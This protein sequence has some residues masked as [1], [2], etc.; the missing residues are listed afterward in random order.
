MPD[1]SPTPPEADTVT[2]EPSADTSPPAAA[3][4]ATPA[5]QPAAEKPLQAPVHGPDT[6]P[7]PTSAPAASQSP[8]PAGEEAPLP[9]PPEPVGFARRAAAAV[10]FALYGAV[11]AAAWFVLHFWGLELAPF[12]TKGEPREGLVVW[13]MTHGGGLILPRRN[14]DELPSKPPLFHWLGALTSRVAGRTDEWSIRF[15]SAALSLVGTLA[16]FAA[17][18]ALWSARAGACAA[19]A[20]TT[21][22]EWSRAATSARV[23]M[24][25]TVALEIA[26]LALLFFLRAPST[27]WLVTLY[28]GIAFA[29]L[30][31]GPVGAALPG[32]LA[33]VVLALRRDFSPLRHMR[34]VRGGL[35][36]LLI[37][38]TWY[39]LAW[40][41]GGD[42]FL[43]KQVL[44]ENV[45]T[46]LRSA[47]YRTSGHNHSAARLAGEWM[48]GLLPWTLFLP[49]VVVGLWSDRRTLHARDARVYLLSW[50][51]VVWGFYSLAASKRG[52]YLLAAYP[53]LALL[54]GWWWDRRCAAGDAEPPQRWL[55]GVAGLAGWLL[56][57]VVVPVLLVVALQAGGLPVA[58]WVAEWLPP[59]LQPYAPWASEIVATARNP[60]LAALAVAVVG[61]YLLTH[62]ARR[63]SWGRIFV[64]MFVAAAGLTAAARL[65]VL[66]GI[67]RHTT[68]REFMNAVRTEVGSEPLCF[69]KAFDYGAIFYSR[70]H[71]P[72]CGG[73][74]PSTTPRYM[75]LRRTEWA[76]VANQ[77]AGAYESV[78]F[79]AGVE[80]EGRRSLVLVR[81]IAPPANP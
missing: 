25:L 13:E 44:A 57:A 27:P 47:Q 5:S 45:F 21:M 34:L 74:W 46:F 62:G 32:L 65:A 43:R 7:A 11:V 66:P 33:L 19:L 80:S 76:R 3:A 10:R 29:V 52:V 61:L 16:V 39:V 77:A 4:D 71:I 63:T 75:L 54:L 18:G 35:A 1:S 73:D 12:H 70:G 2:H 22:F 38:G 30:G 59:N 72:R 31:K 67:A 53:A 69:W 23:D 55:A 8:T 20:L 24:T 64:G 9:S 48:L 14:G 40:W 17:G 56:A 49:G 78:P 79:P 15:P 42:A 81:R 28:L 41:D 68:T 36:V 60:L 58:T 26:F 6:R 37:A 51:V 50:T